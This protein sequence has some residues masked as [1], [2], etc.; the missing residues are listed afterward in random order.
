MAYE[1][2]KKSIC[3]NWCF[4]SKK[5]FPIEIVLNVRNSYKYSC[6]KLFKRTL[7]TFK[8]LLLYTFL[9][10]CGGVAEAQHIHGYIQNTANEPIPYAHIFIKEL[11]SGTTSDERG[12]YFLKI[13]PGEY[14]VIYSAL[15][16]ETHTV[17][18]IIGEVPIQ[19]NIWMTPS[20]I[21]LQQVVVRAAKRDPAYAIIQ[22]AID[23]KAAYLRDLP[24][25]RA[26][27]YLKACEEI[28]EKTAK[29]KKKKE[30]KDEGFRPDADPFAEAERKK[31]EEV[32]GLSLV[33]IALFLNY[34]FPKK[35]KEERT[36]YKAYGDKEG[37]FV[38]LF[39]ESDFNFYRNLV[40]SPT[41]TEVPIISPL[42]RT[43]VLS[44]KFKLLESK[45]EGDNLVH[46][47]KVTPRKKGNAT[48]RGYIYINEGTWNINRLEL[49]FAK[50][51]LR[52]F[53]AFTIKQTYR[54]W[55]DSIWLPQR[56]EFVYATKQGKRKTFK[57][58]TLI[59]YEDYDFD[60]SFPKNFFGNELS[61]TTQAAYERDSTYWKAARPE[62]LTLRQQKLVAY[63]DSIFAVHNS[64]A[65]K[66]SM[67][68]LYNKVTLTDLVWD[69]VGFRNHEA[70]KSIFFGPLPTI[71]DF[72][73]V[74]GFRVGLPYMAAFKKWKNERWLSMYGVVNVGMVNKDVQGDFSSRYRYAPRRL[75]DVYGSVGRTF[76]AI[77][78]YDAFLNQ[79]RNSNYYLNDYLF[80]GHRIELFNGFYLRTDFSVN[81]R[82]STAHLVG[83]NFIGDLIGDEPAIDF[84]PYRAFI[85]DIQIDYT[86]RQRYL[87]EPF[88]KVVLGS[89]FPTFQLRYKR[90]WNHVFASD[91]DFDFVEFGIAQDLVLGYFGNSKYNVEVGRFLNTRNLKFIDFKRFRQSDPWW[92]SNPLHSFQLLDTALA[93]TQVFVEAHHI[94]HFNGALINN[95]P[96]VRALRIHVVLGGGIMYVHEGRVRHEEVFAGV[97]RTFKLGPRRRLRLGAYGVL[98]NSNFA[99]TSIGYKFSIDLIDTW[100]KKWDF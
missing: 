78:S 55:A 37:L 3:N 100:D 88:R 47:I 26:K 56:V 85:S 31:A 44:Y 43:A 86:P 76:E 69:G 24:A 6:S 17:V 95:I 35:Y 96:L 21:A 23:A 51:G 97:E 59:R 77:N 50:G 74:G 39:G 94:H 42:N 84:A 80:L 16:Y 67:Q 91:I 15:G 54:Q 49:S 65:Y 98:A 73:I 66:D 36:A 58:N 14:E 22:H 71:L 48:C 53:D 75:G 93:T 4:L 99:K 32:A 25:Y 10:L 13:E 83:E 60:V 68:A 27:V 82:Q 40:F 20:D 70:K 30:K 34:Q 38:P 19:K 81:N 87:T 90:G 45:M 92:Y 33:E 5:R 57:G 46:K 18:L 52:F 11:G 8:Q 1:T 7:P 41:L 72:E 79:L 64:K 12:Y 62:P 63:K 29:Q 61:V 28:D 2:F 9:F 89:K